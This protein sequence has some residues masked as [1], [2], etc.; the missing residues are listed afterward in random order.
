MSKKQKSASREVSRPQHGRQEQAES[1]ARHSEIQHADGDLS[2]EQVSAQRFWSGAL[3]R[4]EDL[5]KYNAIVPGAAERILAM[6]EKEQ[7]HRIALEQQIVPA[8]ATAGKH[9]QWLGAGISLLA[10]LSAAFTAVMGAPW[11][12]SVALV[13]VPVPSVARSLV[14]AFKTSDDD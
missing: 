5:A 3:P 9:G 14:T 1:V 7:E 11:Q 8:N 6:A 13:G 4:P 2:V 10:L 12:V